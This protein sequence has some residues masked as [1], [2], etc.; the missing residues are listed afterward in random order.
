[1]KTLIFDSGTLISFS[2]NGL[3]GKLKLLKDLNPENKFLITEDV[4][5]EIIDKPLNI[6]KFELEALRVQRLFDTGV[7]E[8]PSAIGVSNKEISKRTNEMLAV[9]NKLFVSKNGQE[10]KIISAGET[11]CL[12]LA[13]ILQEKK[14][15]VTL[16]VDERTMR[17]LVEKPE[18][19]KDLLER[20]M[21]TGV[22]LK[23]SDFK[24]FKGFKIIRS[25]E[26]IYVAWKKGFIN[27]KGPKVLDALLWAM[28]SKG[29]AITEDE[30][31]EI[32]R[33]R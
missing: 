20:R 8:L 31:E 26:L 14:F 5:S 2:M 1:M 16:A 18:N 30:I 29:C 6:H 3:L 10:I 12:A 22:K 13:R 15:D 28:K 17:L 9:A 33:L 21:H 27:F 4:K 7:L 32:K 23:K 11:S 24:M 19:L 25:T